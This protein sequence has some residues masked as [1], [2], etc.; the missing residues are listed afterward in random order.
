MADKVIDSLA[1]RQVRSYDK[2][3]I[4]QLFSYRP[5]IKPSVDNYTRPR[6]GQLS[7]FGLDIRGDMKTAV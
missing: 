1:N 4:T 5:Y 6:L 2:D 7:M 3:V